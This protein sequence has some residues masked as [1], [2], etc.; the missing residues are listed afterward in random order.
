MNGSCDQLFA[1][2]VLTLDQHPRVGG[3]DGGD[4]FVEGL[5]GSAVAADGVFL[6][7]FFAQIAVLLFQSP[8]VEGVVDG[9][10]NLIYIEG[11]FDQVVGP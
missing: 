6:D 1:G 10:D 8:E 3:G 2:A 5:H 7:G 4:L 11:F 9:H